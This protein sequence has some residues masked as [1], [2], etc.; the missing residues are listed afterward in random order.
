MHPYFWLCN[1]AD[2]CV[3]W[4]YSSLQPTGQICCNE[5]VKVILLCVSITSTPKSTPAPLAALVEWKE[6]AVAREERA[7]LGINQRLRGVGHKESSK[8]MVLWWCGQ[9]AAWNIEIAAGWKS[10]TW[11]RHGWGKMANWLLMPSLI[12]TKLI[13]IN[14]TTDLDM[15]QHKNWFGSTQTHLD[16]HKQLIWI[17]TNQHKHIWINTNILVDQHKHIWINTKV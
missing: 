4:A 14:T 5:K 9:S 1:V 10:K 8:R 2:V 15:I 11:K 17:N 13:W 3:K 6:W 7:V 12:I 16:Q